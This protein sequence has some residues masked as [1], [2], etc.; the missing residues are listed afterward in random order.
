M[1]KIDR[2]LYPTDFSDSA[3]YALPRAVQ[4]AEEHEA[5]LHLLHAVVLH[6]GDE[7]A[8]ESHYQE[9]AEAAR[10]Q[11]EAMARDGPAPHLRLVPVVRRGISPGPVILDYAEGEEIDLIVM[12]SHG[13]RGLRRL[14]LGSVAAEVLRLAGIPVLTVRQPRHAEPRPPGPIER[15]VIPMDFSSHSNVAL[16]YAAELA[17]TFGSRLH[18]LHV[19]D[20]LV[21]PDFYL[22]VV[23]PDANLPELRR[24]ARERLEELA[25]EFRR[26]RGAGLV[27]ETEVRVERAAHT[28]AEY[29]EEIEAD[30][31]VMAS[32]GLRGLERVLLGS[33][34]EGVMTHAPCSLLT[35]RAFGKSLLTS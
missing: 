21:Y 23:F 19:I 10:E 1:L 15:I 16:E 29:A 17:G 22:P 4:F 18:L 12:G 2:I 20:R 7:A 30:L 31:I 25:A 27:V 28:I 11:L 33:V 8:L 26:G 34:A 32:H 13:R 6:G 35:V 3:A 24:R 5:E 9:V 14:L